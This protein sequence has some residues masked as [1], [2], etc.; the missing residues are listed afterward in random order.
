MTVDTLT[1]RPATAA[2][3]QRRCVGARRGLHGIPAAVYNRAGYLATTPARQE[4][5][6]AV[7]RRPYLGG[8][9]RRAGSA[10]TVAA[11]LRDD[12]V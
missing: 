6:A 8:R 11:I 7:R 3:A 10:G 4:I 5:E 12:G 9:T 1:I 2:D